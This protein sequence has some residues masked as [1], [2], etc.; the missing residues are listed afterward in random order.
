[1]SAGPARDADAVIVG[2]GPNG[3]AA[4]VVLA[5]AGLS[6][7]VLEA[8]STL[9]GGARTLDLGLAPGL[10]HDLCSAVHPLAVASPF[11]RE[12]DLRSRGVQLVTPEVSYGQPFDTGPAALAHRDLG[13]TAAGMG[14]DARAWER[15]F[16]PLLAAPDALVAAALG[17][18]RSLPPLTGGAGGRDG[19]RRGAPDG[20]RS[21]DRLT[22]I[23]ALGSFGLRVAGEGTPLWNLPWRTE[24]AKA[25]LTGVATH[26]IGRQP[27]LTTAGT[28]L[29]LAT[30]AHADGWPIPRGGSQAITDALVADLTA[31]GGEVRTGVRVRSVEDLPPAR[32]VL[33]DTTA[34]AAA[35]VLGD[36]LP[37]RVGRGL[38]GL[39]HGPGAAKVDL[40]LDG[41]IPWADP[42][43]GDAGTVHVGGTR[44]E[45]AAA[46]AQVVAGR[47]PARP[48]VLVSDP[49]RF[50]ASRVVDG[51]RPVWAYAHVPADCPIDPT[52]SVLAQIE[53]FA[54]GFRERVV[55]VRGTP[56]SRMAEHNA[57]LVGGDISGGRLGPARLVARPRWAWETK[58]LAG[59]SAYLCSAATTPGPGVHGMAGFHA[60]R[61]VLAQRFGIRDG[62]SLGV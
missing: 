60:A 53:R 18:K 7:V 55:A 41:P 45:M 40:V 15:F 49:G 33:F 42:R 14:P 58:R 32:A 26:A 62:V 17:D 1:M 37:A 57:N 31:H 30:L 20:P 19:V 16:R 54:P 3:L 5:R 22:A 61:D 47:M 34:E 59:T 12:F 24:R 44:A 51:L 46:E 39:G 4:A 27:S 35:A 38:R 28:G 8:E 11:F 36:A 2:S 25:L 43:L 48:V 52:R 10:V 9:G 13:R 50:D 6:V 56:A 21:A 29:L 23:R